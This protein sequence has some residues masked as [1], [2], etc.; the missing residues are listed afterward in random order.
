MPKY[1]VIRTVHNVHEFDV[2]AKDLTEAYIKADELY[3]ASP[4]PF[5]THFSDIRDVG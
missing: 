5:E 1:H 4:A 2:V 3:E